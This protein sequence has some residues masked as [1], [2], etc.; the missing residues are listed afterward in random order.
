MNLSYVTEILS[1]GLVSLILALTS[2]GGDGAAVSVGS[3]ESLLARGESAV[4][5]KTP[6]L[7]AITI[8]PTNPLGIKSGTKLRLTASGSYSDNSVQD[9]TTMVVWTT[10]D[11]SVATVSN[12]PDSKGLAL[13]VYVGYC[14]ISATLGNVSGSTVIGVKNLSSA[15][16]LR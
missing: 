8:S 12:E 16:A 11:A 5:K 6:V 9:I 15:P 10:S 1:C 14:S 3:R 2:C 13:A 4:N 7:V